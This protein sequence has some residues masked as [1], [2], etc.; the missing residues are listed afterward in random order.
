MP[1]VGGGHQIF[2][3]KC[4]IVVSVEGIN[5]CCFG[6]IHKWYINEWAW[7]SSSKILFTKIDDK[8]HVAHGS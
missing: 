6:Y 7:L 2:S 8:S 5:L 3:V 4:H 1:G